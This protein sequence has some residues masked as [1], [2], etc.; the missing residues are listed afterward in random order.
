[1]RRRKEGFWLLFTFFPQPGTLWRPWSSP[2]CPALRIRVNVRT[3]A[4]PSWVSETQKEAFSLDNRGAAPA[5]RFISRLQALRLL[6]PLPPATDLP[7][8]STVSALTSLLVLRWQRG[9]TGH[10]HHPPVKDEGEG[11][12]EKSRV[13]EA[14]RRNGEKKKKSKKEAERGQ[15]DKEKMARKEKRN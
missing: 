8:A 4:K 9:L 11:W 7:P 12:A 14:E 6:V 13:G 1:M 15:G 10:T 5:P 3:S 2:P